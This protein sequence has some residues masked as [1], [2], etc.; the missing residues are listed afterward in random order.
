[1]ASALKSLFLLT[2]T[3]SII[4]RGTTY[5]RLLGSQFNRQNHILH[6]DSAE[7]KVVLADNGDTI[8][9]WHPEKP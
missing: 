9:C 2:Q 8:V 6:R 5:G 1:M 7:D 3:R 4:L